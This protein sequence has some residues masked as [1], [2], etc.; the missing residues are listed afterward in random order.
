MSPSDLHEDI[1]TQGA[2]DV[3]LRDSQ[4]REETRL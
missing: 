4:R 2:A 3:A 1:Q